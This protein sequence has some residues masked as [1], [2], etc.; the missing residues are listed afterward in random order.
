MAVS[1][2]R[3]TAAADT[4]KRAW[5]EPITDSN[6]SGT[7]GPEPS[8]PAARTSGSTSLRPRPPAPRALAR[9]KDD[10][11]RKAHEER[12]YRPRRPKQQPLPALE[13]ASPE[14]P[15]HP[16]PRRVGDRAPVAHDSAVRGPERNRLHDCFFAPK[17]KS[18]AT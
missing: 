15:P 16:R 14:Q 13:P 10:V 4:P 18:P 17:T 7:A 11:D 1:T 5:I 2:R 3:V 6:R 8:V 12:V 9:E